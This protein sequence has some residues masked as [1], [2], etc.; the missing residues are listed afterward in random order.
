MLPKDT[1]MMAKA[2]LTEEMWDT[3]EKRREVDLSYG[4]SG[5]SRFRVNIFYQRS[6]IS[7]A[8]RVIPRKIPSIDELGIPKILEKV[9]QNPHGLFCGTGPTGSGKS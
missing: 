5:V 6:A 7:L 3:L 1:S 9:V 4:I 8:F 2:I